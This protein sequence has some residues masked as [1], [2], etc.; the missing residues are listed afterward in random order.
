MGEKA[1]KKEKIPRQAMPEQE[2]AVRAKNFEEVPVG[3]SPET[4]ILE[5][6]RCLQCKKPAC[7]AGCPVEVDIPGFIDRVKEG[8]FTGA[9]K[10]IWEKNALPA[11]CGRVCP[12]ELQCEGN[13]IVGKKGDAVA[14]GQIV[15][16]ALSSGTVVAMFNVLKS[17]IDRKPSLKLEIE[18][19]D[20]KKLKIDAENLKKTQ[21]DQT[22]QMAKEL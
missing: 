20:G 4:A 5:A 9:I 14:I 19:P 7:V 13:C 11:V 2:P 10:K 21:I 8:D 6:E 3:Q 17:Y 16:A 15:L 12:Q 1:P 18:T 22:I